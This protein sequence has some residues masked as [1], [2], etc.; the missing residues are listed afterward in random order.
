VRS[1][2]PPAKWIFIVDSSVVGYDGGKNVRDE[3]RPV[4]Q[5][6][7]AWK[8]P[9][10]SKHRIDWPRWTGFR[11]MT[12]RD[13]LPIVGALL[14]P[15]V[16]ALGTWGITWQQ[17]KIEDQ[18]ALDER[19]LEDQRAQD[20]ALQAYLDHMTKLMLNTD[21]QQNPEQFPASTIAR[22]RTL[23]VIERLDETRKK[24]VM[25]F[26]YEAGLI[27]GSDPA[28]SLSTADL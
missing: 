28:I 3:E 17:G 10:P 12:L 8:A 24:R 1:S 9:P 13:W 22:A 27:N 25:R 19:E 5:K 16:I 2:T 21:L 20:E 18:R 23:T 26:L 11:G 14:I 6:K 7:L 15:V 4:G